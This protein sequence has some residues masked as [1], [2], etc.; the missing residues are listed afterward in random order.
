[1]GRDS[2]KRFEIIEFDRDYHTVTDREYKNFSSQTEA[3]LWC[4]ENSWTGYDYFA[5]EV[6]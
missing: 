4:E 6:K 3:D 1:M 2:L 5:K